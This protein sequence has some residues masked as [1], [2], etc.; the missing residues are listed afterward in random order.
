MS[1]RRV[2]LL[3]ASGFLGTNLSLELARYDGLEVASPRDSALF[4]GR[5]RDIQY[6][7]REAVGRLF[8]D[9]RPDAVINCVG[10][11]GHQAADRSP[12]LADELNVHFP[13]LLGNLCR[14][15]GAHLIHFSTDAV[16]SSD[17]LE[18]PFAETSPTAPFSSYGRTKLK[19][20]RVLSATLESVTILRVNF[21]GWSRTGKRGVL[22]HFVMAGLEERIAIGF[23]RYVASSIYVGD[24]ARVVASLVFSESR[25][26]FNLGSSD[27]LSKFQFGLNVAEV[28]GWRKDGVVDRDPSEWSNL[29]VEARDLTMNSSLIQKE[30]RIALTTQSEGIRRALS[31]LEGF[32]SFVGAPDSDKRWNLVR[33]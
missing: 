10:I 12:E 4:R 13:V 6:S 19:A 17:P 29:G 31:D 25:G 14:D 16:Y 8:A 7:D 33:N 23:G 5:F 11:V 22:D 15:S 3:G 20:E 27:S 2:L 32:L 26:V 1:K 18:A 28:A 9:A 30:T 24:L 21:F